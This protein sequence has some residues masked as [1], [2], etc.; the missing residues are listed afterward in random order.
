MYEQI[1]SELRSL[2]QWGLYQKI[3]QPEKHKYTK[4]PW[5]AV[6]GKRASSTN[7]DDWT[8]FDNALQCLKQSDFAGLGFFF[9]DGYVGIDVDHIGPDLDRLENGDKQDNIAFEFLDAMKSYAETSLSGEGIHIIIRGKLPGS[10][11]RKKNVEMYESG[12]FFAMTGNK[13][14]P[15]SGINKPDTP[16]LKKLYEKYIEPKSVLK[17]PMR[18]DDRFAVNNLSEDEIIAKMLNS[19]TGDRIRLLLVGGWEKFY[20][21][22]SEADLALANDLAFWTGRDFSKMDS[23]FRGSSLMRPKWDEKHGKTTYGVATLNKAINETSNV[24]HPERERMKY[25]LS[26]LMGESKKPKKKLPPR[27][28]DDTGNAQ[29]F[30]DHF[31]DAA[32]YSYVDKAWYVYNGSYWELDKQGKLG[33]MVDIV[34][35]D[36]KREKIVIAD[37]MDPEEA[38]KKWSKFLKQSRSNSAKKAMTEQLRHRLAVMPEEFD[39]DKILL[40]TINGYVDLS[41]GELHDHDVKKM[42]SKET[43]VEYTDTVDAPEWRQFLDQIF[44]HDE[45]LIDY[46]QKA[47]G[48]SLTGST[49]EQVMFILYGN[50]RNGKSVFM[51]TLK[52]VAGSYAKSM[53]AKSIMIKQSDSAANSDIARLKGARLVTASEPNEGVRLDEGL[54]KELTGGDMVTARFLYGSE[55]EY[56][57]EFKLWLATNHKPIIRGT[58]DGIWRRLMLIP[59][60]VQIPENKV[61]KRLAYKLERESVGI[62]NWAVDGA[63]KWQREGLKAPSSVQAA[64]KSYRAEMDT[65]ELFVRDCCDLGPDYQAPAGELFKAYQSWAESNGEYKMRKQ[66]FSAEMKNKFVYKKN[67]SRYYLGLRIKLDPRLSWMSTGR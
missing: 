43:G 54:V 16:A 13:I 38:K 23:I 34:V 35:D 60:N 57:P 42:F 27:S 40:N 19:K 37:G 36:M 1:P 4:I 6:T 45:E 14:G 20:T 12:R 53:S 66:K 15:Y 10:R 49:E 59:F 7:P 29:R 31:G 21:S 8:T 67:N 26:G 56:K 24:Y 50:G 9:V 64:S 47:I 63:L 22:Q 55:F 17:M 5:S 61:D 25:D 18:T 46:L 58:D 2:K 44:D 51:D 28:W 41:D 30:V 32:R 48:Y 33:S 3:W 52:H 62:L 65:L 11:H 39:R